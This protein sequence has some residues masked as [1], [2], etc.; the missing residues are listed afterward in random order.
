[1]PSIRSKSLIF[2]IYGAFVRDLGGWIAIADLITLMGDLGVEEQPVRSSVS[3]MTRKGMLTRHEQNG[4]A[5]YVLSPRAQEILAEG[6]SR[7]YLQQETASVDDGWTLVTFSIPETMRSERHQ[8]R[9]R[10]RWLGYGNVGAGL[11]I[12]P[13]RTYDRTLEMVRSSGLARYVDVFRATYAAFGDLNELVRRCWDLDQVRQ[14]YRLY[15]SE[16]EP[17]AEKWSNPGPLSEPQ[18]AFRDYVSALHRWRKLPYL[19]PGLPPELLPGEWEGKIATDL[20]NDLRS[21]LEPSARDHVAS[22]VSKH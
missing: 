20:F 18:S 10:L 21:R 2:D 16:F 12:A 7:I 1:M 22:T 11:W 9:S 3:R 5:G 13:S 15:L 6:D 17:M 19:D 4:Q 8:L 14:A